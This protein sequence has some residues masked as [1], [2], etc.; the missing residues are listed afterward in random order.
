MIA[1][2]VPAGMLADNGPGRSGGIP[3]CRYILGAGVL[4]VGGPLDRN[5]IQRSGAFLFLALNPIAVILGPLG[6]TVRHAVADRLPKSLKP[7]PR[8]GEFGA[9]D[10][11]SESDAQQAGP[12]RHYHYYAEQNHRPTDNCDRDALRGLVSQICGLLDHG[13]LD[14]SSG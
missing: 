14:G 13:N 1:I 6:A 2:S 4:R 10:R 11:E 8:P 9:Q 5:R 12:R 7:E 3:P